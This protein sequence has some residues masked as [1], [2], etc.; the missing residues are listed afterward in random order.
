MSVGDR[1]GQGFARLNSLAGKQIR[2][3][4]YNIVYDDIYDEP[5]SLTLSGTTWTSGIVLPLDTSQGSV[6]SVLLEQG[7]LIG[8]DQ[9]LYVSGGI[10]L[11]GSDLKLKIGVGS[12]VTESFNVMDTIIGAEASNVKVYKKLFIRRL[13]GSLIGE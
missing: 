8:H 13:T 1:L 5:L 10:G 7:K 4:Y 12:P 9:T 2:I 6:D 11:T 3:D